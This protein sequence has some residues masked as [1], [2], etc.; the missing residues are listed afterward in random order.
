MKT[1]GGHTSPISALRRA[2]KTDEKWAR[3]QSVFKNAYRPEF[4]SFIPMIQQLHSTR[5]LR[6]LGAQAAPSGAKIAD[7][8]LRDQSTRSRCVEICMIVAR[9][10]NH[11]AATMNTIQSYLEAEY[12]SLLSQHGARSMT[13]KRGLIESLFGPA[14]RKLERLDTIPEIAEMVIK[15]VDQASWMLKTLVTAL[16]IATAREKSI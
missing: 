2:L 15:D 10:R 6:V 4:D 5:S 7:A 16:E 11:L 9:E 3:F 8:A 13:E 12:G 14:Q 1:S